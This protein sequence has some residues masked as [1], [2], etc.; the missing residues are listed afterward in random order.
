MTMSACYFVQELNPR[1]GSMGLVGFRSQV[2]YF[3]LPGTSEFLMSVLLYSIPGAKSSSVGTWALTKGWK[4][5]RSQHPKH[6]SCSSAPAWPLQAMRVILQLLSFSS[7]LCLKPVHHL[8]VLSLRIHIWA[9]KN[10]LNKIN[11]ESK[12]ACSV[13]LLCDHEHIKFSGPRFPNWFR[14]FSIVWQEGTALNYS[15]SERLLISIAME[16]CIGVTYRMV[17]VNLLFYTSTPRII[18]KL[19]SHTTNLGKRGERK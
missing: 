4:T 9:G 2:V 15:M 14:N 11:Q 3:C 13:H 19:F 7:L 16:I 5:L 18:S 12:C 1:G 8:R 10:F 6:V 17:P